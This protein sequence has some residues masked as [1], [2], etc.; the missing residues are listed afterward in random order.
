MSLPAESNNPACYRTPGTKNGHLTVISCLLFLA[1]LKGKKTDCENIT[2]T[3]LVEVEP[4]LLINPEDIVPKEPGSSEETLRTILRPGDKVSD[5][6]KTTSSEISA[7]V[8]ANPSICKH[9]SFLVQLIDLHT[10]KCR[11]HSVSSQCS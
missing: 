11:V 7:V 10:Q 5:Q 2:E 9:A 3:S 6:Y 4:G 1:F 8:G